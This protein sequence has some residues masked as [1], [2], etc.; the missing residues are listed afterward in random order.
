LLSEP[1][2]P[3]QHRVADYENHM[4]VGLTRSMLSVSRQPKPLWAQA[5][6]TAAYVLNRTGK[7][8][9]SGKSPM[10]MWNGHVMKNVYHLH[11]FGMECFVYTAKQ[12]RKNFN[13]KSVF[14]QL[15]VEDVVVEKRQE[16]DTLLESLQLNKTLKVETKEEFSRNTE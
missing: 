13:K 6:E 7:I 1:Y 14:G 16:G 12:F 8:S 10:E 2:A 3:E 15:I 4:V 5:C 9:V 11:V